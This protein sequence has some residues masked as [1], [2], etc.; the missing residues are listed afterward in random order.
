MS[1]IRIGARR[2][3]NFTMIDRDAVRDDRLSFRAL[4]LLTWLL[5]HPDDWRISSEQLGRLGRE[6]RDAIRSAM[7]EL[8]EF[9]YLVRRRWRDAKGHFR[10]EVLVIECPSCEPVT[11]ADATKTQVRPETDFQAS[12]DQASVRQ[13]SVPQ[14]L[15]EEVL[16]ESVTGECDE[17]EQRKRPTSAV[18]HFVAN[19]AERGRGF[20]S[21]PNRVAY[22]ILSDL[23]D[24]DSELPALH[25]GR[26]TGSA[27]L[28][29]AAYDQDERAIRDAIESV[30]DAMHELVEEVEYRWTPS[31]WWR[32]L[33][34]HVVTALNLDDVDFTPGDDIG[35]ILEAARARR[36]S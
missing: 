16:R 11:S 24:A 17:E 7:R 19:G 3:R 35:Q 6:G 26:L 15:L 36:A 33:V 30:L 25:K 18:S 28:L 10:T 1:I 14:A 32:C 27:D 20:E 9:G 31:L 34:E 4:G 21:Y 8:D 5:D 22:R 23:N 2:E 13:A 12:V 29:A